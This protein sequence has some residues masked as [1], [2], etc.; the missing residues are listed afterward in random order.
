V[1]V[2]RA[3]RERERPLDPGP[4]AHEEP[5]PEASSLRDR[6]RRREAR[7][8]LAGPVA[9]AARAVAPRDTPARFAGL[10]PGRVV[11]RVLDRELG[12]AEQ[13]A[14]VP[15]ASPVVLTIEAAGARR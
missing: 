10:P 1:Y 2:E 12:E 9:R 13:A 4:K 6:P 5:D 8:R 7:A 11:L 15:A 3:T 14:D